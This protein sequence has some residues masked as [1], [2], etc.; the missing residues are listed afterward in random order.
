MTAPFRERVLARHF[1]WVLAFCVLATIAAA[2]WIVAKNGQR[3]YTDLSVYQYGF[4]AW[5][6]DQDM[7][8]ALPVPLPFIYPPFSLV[9]LAPFAAVPLKVAGI[10]TFVVSVMA[11]AVTCYLVI[12]RV[13][14][15][16]DR[17]VTIAV[18]ALAVPL[19]MMLEPIQETIGLGQVNL[20]LMALVAADCLAR[21]PRWPRGAL[22]GLAAAIKITPA[23]F[24][25]FFLLRKDFRAIRTAAITGASVTGLGLL[26][27]PRES[28][29]YWFGGVFATG[30]GLAG[31]TFAS[32]Q[33]IA[34]AIGRLT[35]P[36]V[37]A[38]TVKIA[39]IAAAIVACVV[40]MSRVEPPIALIVNAATA[41]L[42]SPVS[43]SAHWV[44][45]GP[46][47]LVIAACALR[48]RNTLAAVAVVAS[49]TVFCL[50]PHWSLP[51]ANDT[52]LHWTWWQQ[53]VGNSYTLVAF[54]ALLT[55]ALYLGLGSTGDNS[56]D[57]LGCV[58]G[59]HRRDVAD[60][61]PAVAR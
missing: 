3:A 13:R 2:A 16:K 15:T 56:P 5:W 42:I 32:N 27:A 60:L 30:S 19:L 37:V 55:S 17:R 51:R 24:L 26:I 1:Q 49:M 25:L 61:G 59:H 34:A 33:C 9:V 41:L 46:A 21:H 38:W 40:V 20:W 50:G 36:S 10:A 45:I 7:Y 18:S 14:P 52:E 22:I 43:W 44:W 53:I 47:V 31:T 4:R 57:P 48:A 12:G 58:R 23:A 6:H 28:L 35:L 8:G 11:L 54:A 39:L 29:H